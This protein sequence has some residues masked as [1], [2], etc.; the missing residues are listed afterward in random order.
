MKYKDF[1]LKYKEIL[2]SNIWIDASE[3]KLDF[4]DLKLELLKQ[5]SIKLDKIVSIKSNG[6]LT[7]RTEGN[8]S[9]TSEFYQE[10]SKIR[11][12]SINI[13]DVCSS[14]QG[15]CFSNRNENINWNIC[16]NHYSFKNNLQVSSIYKFYDKISYIKRFLNNHFAFAVIN[17]SY[18]LTNRTILI[19]GKQLS[20][21]L[22]NYP[23]MLSKITLET[24]NN[25][26]IIN[27]DL[28]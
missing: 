17:D 25:T 18:L 12:E 11:S 6:I 1:K 23:E 14:N 13:C 7:I 27:L 4:L 21:S 3:A 16:K 24:M 26:L 9:H 19:L 10:L 20:I 8:L 15:I 5:Q 2:I 22:S 28:D